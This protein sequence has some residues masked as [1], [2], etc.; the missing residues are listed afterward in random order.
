MLTKKAKYGL[1]AMLH[2]AR[3]DYGAS[4]F[5]ASIAK[6]NALPKKFLDA[7]LTEL[8]NAGF[9]TSKTGRN[10]GYMLARRPEAISVGSIIRTLDGP[11]APIACASRTSY[12][13][14][15]DC[16]TI[17]LCEIRIMMLEVREAIAGV[18]D[19]RTLAELRDARADPM[20]SFVYEI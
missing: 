8:R 13:P 15:S 16:G 20:A 3:L 14:C 12:A 18:L 11:L 2:L 7:I 9:L 19:H 17:E 5:V 1:K 10:G 6:D 4:A